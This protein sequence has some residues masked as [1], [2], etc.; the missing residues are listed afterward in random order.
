[1]AAGLH[2]AWRIARRS[3]LLVAAAIVVPLAISA[4]NIR[5]APEAAP[6]PVLIGLLP[7]LIGKFVLCPLRW[8]Q[9]S[10]G[11]HP[12]AGDLRGYPAGGR[13]GDPPPAPPP[14]PGGGG[15]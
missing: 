8:H 7:F 11:G 3:R 10:A 12:R 1:M 13:V 2:R 6:L 9:I 14:P 5:N 4:Y 15:A